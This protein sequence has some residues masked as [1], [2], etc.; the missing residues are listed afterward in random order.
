M[1]KTLNHALCFSLVAMFVDSAG[2]QTA[3]TPADQ[4]ATAAA[5]SVSEIPEIMVTAQKRSERLTDVPLSVTAVSADQ[6]AKQGIEDPGDLEKIVP[7]FTY[8]LS[9]NGTP[10]FQIRGIGF[11]DE[12]VA[13][14][15]TVTIYVDQ[16]P[17]PYGRMTE[18]AALDLERVEVLKGPQGTLFGQNATAGAVNYIAAK[19][20]DKFAA[21]VDLDYGRFN[22][23]SAGAFV[24][25]PL[26][27]GLEARFVFKSET[28]G[29]WQINRAGDDTL[30]HRDFQTARLLLDW[31]PTAAL[32]LEFNLNGWLDKSDTQMGQARDY[33]PVSPFP[34][35]TPQ[36]AQTAAGL[37]SYP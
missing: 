32:K 15:P 5:S 22:A 12:Q 3:A 27:E 28:R 18:G 35:L 7:G 33:L 24:S 16:V 6:L 11:Y 30:G 36:T 14:S 26:A 19:P 34:P 2:A 23:V 4:P 13:V 25:G 20:T 21:G 17:L 37:T 29:D 1:T 10:I 9:Q 31:Q 8:R